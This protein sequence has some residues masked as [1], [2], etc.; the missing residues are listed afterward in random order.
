MDAID[1][2]AVRV[3]FG[4]ELIGLTG[5]C[6]GRATLAGLVGERAAAG[7]QPVTEGESG[8]EVFRAPGG[9]EYAKC[10]KREHV[11][12]LEQERDRV[13]WL[14]RHGVPGPS[15]LDWTAD[16]TGACLLTSAVAGVPADKA[17]DGE[18]RRAWPSIAEATRALHELPAGDC[19]FGRELSAMLALADDV[20]G[21]GAV[22][23][24]FLQPD[25]RDVA[26]ERQL[27]S[28]R[29]QEAKRAAQE[30]ADIVVCHGDLC[31]PNIMLDPETMRFTGFVDLGRL[32]R[33]D[34][35]ADLALVLANARE[36]WPDEERARHADEQFAKYYGLPLDAERL[37]FYLMLDPL[38][39]G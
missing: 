24:D 16:E 21:R 17:D 27:A 3:S 30:A 35:H 26:P 6:H 34:R 37:R 11:A 22:D 32:G 23:P 7:W 5:A 31:L 9:T 39:W 19:P 38:T 1:A 13:A 18:L 25:Q 14:S 20:V 33:A 2:V 4:E 8:A 12:A 15:V 10:V 36:T 29:A 28:L